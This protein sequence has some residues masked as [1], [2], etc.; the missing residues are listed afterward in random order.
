VATGHYAKILFEDGIYHLMKADDPVKDQSYF[1]FSH[2]QATLAR[3]LFPLETITKPQVR[4][5][6]RLL[7]L[8]IAEKPESQEICFVTQERYDKFIEATGSAPQDSSGSIRH[9][10]GRILGDH[11]GYWR[12]TIGQRKGLGIAHSRP[13]YVAGIDPLTHTVWVGE[14][15]HLLHARLEARDTNWCQGQ[16]PAPFR[17]L[18]KLRSRSQEVPAWVTPLQDGKV[19]VVFESPQRAITPGQAIVFYQGPEVLGGAW[20]HQVL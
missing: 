12:F 11:E 7:N 1:L 5:L 19:Q 14:D 10:D 9:L 6:A 16:P 20:I 4:G 3:S 18:A 8:P 15:E 2:T 17:C 13:L